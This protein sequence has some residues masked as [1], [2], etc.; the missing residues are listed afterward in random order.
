M[1]F[2]VTDPDDRAVLEA[3]R[4]WGVAP[5]VFLG[6]GRSVTEHQYNALGQ[7]VRSSTSSAWTDDD[8]TAALDL[9]AH[10]A[11][12]CPGCG[13]PVAETTA[14]EAEERYHVPYPIRCHRCTAT[15]QAQVRFQDMPTPAALLLPVQVRDSPSEG[16]TEE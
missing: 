13:H 12:L 7:L 4:A 8:R 16:G 15:E 5:S 2:D 11:S 3:A 14:P 10:E 1:K 9:L 6:Y